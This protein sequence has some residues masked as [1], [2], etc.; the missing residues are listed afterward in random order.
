LN[1]L[2]SFENNCKDLLDLLHINIKRPTL[3][4]SIFEKWEE[5]L[6]IFLEISKDSIGILGGGKKKTSNIIDIATMPI[7]WKGVLHQYA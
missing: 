6:K 2:P 4:D 5:K 1:K 7:S 3:K